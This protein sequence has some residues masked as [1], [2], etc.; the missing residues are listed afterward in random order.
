[1]AILT[2]AAE[3]QA[4][5]VNFIIPVLGAAALLRYLVRGA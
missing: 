4:V 5:L 1:M 2:L 3:V